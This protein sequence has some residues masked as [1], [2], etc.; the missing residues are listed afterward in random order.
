MFWTDLGVVLTCGDNSHGCLGQL[1][2][3]SLL[4]PKRIQQ[5]DGVKIIKVAC[6][7]KHVIALSSVLDIYVWGESNDGALGLGNQILLLLTPTRLVNVQ[8]IQKIDDV[9]CG[10]DCSLLLNERGEVYCCGSNAFN[11]LG[12]GS[13]SDNV[14]VFKKITIFKDRKV[15]YLSVGSTHSAFGKYCHILFHPQFSF[16]FKP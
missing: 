6:G 11:K 14:F 4:I 15:K 13:K 12:M 7:S 2:F 5:L 3:K 1:D 8:A 10:P 16:K 9:Y